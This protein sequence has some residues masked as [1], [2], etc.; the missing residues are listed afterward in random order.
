MT[1]GT[2]ETEFAEQV[3][4]SEGPVLVH[5]G[6]EWSASCRQLFPI[7]GQLASSEFATRLRVI[8]VDVDERPELAEAYGIPGIPALLLFRNGQPVSEKHG[9]LPK[10]TLTRWLEQALA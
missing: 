9:A 6:A 3:L 1:P 10:E 7:L 8:T 2:T 5:F 4:Q